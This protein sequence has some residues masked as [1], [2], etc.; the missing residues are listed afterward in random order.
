MIAVET[1]GDL[2]RERRV[3]KKIAGKLFDREL[4]ERHIR[5]ERVDDPLTPFPDLA[6]RVILVTARVCVPS[7]IEPLLRL[8]LTVAFRLQ[9]T[10]HLGFVSVGTLVSQEIIDLRRSRRQSRQVKARAAKPCFASRFRFRLQVLALQ[11]REHEGVER[12]AHPC[13][14][15]YFGER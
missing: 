5:I 4:I 2:L 15:R 7:Q 8:P 9:K 10:I 1:G 13:F 3:G 6:V 12:I 14:V 11:P